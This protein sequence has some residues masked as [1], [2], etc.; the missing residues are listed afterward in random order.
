MGK[1]EKMNCSGPSRF[2]VLFTFLAFVL[3][4]SFMLLFQPL[5]HAV[6]F[7][8]IDDGLYYPRLAQNICNKGVCTYDGITSTNGFH[9]LWL[10]TLLPVYGVFQ[11]P[12]TALKSVYVLI[13]LVQLI[14]FGMF[15][16][17]ARKTRM[18]SSGWIA[19]IFILLLNIRS[20]TIFFSLLESPL[21]LLFYILYIAFC[22]SGGADRFSK[23]FPAFL[24]GILMGLCFL[25]R[26]DSFLLAVAFSVVWVFRKGRSWRSALFS[27]FGCLLLAAPYLA[28]NRIRFGHFETVSAWQKSALHTPVESWNIISSWCLN[29]FVPRVQ[30]VLGL[31]NIPASYLL[32]IML[33]VGLAGLAYAFTG[34]RRQRLVEKFSLFPEYPLFVVLH[35]IFIVMFAPFEAA[36]SAWYWVPEIL[37]AALVAGLCLSDL[38]LFRVPVV[39]AGILL[40]V[41]AQ[42]MLYPKIMERKAMTFAKIEIAEYLREN[43]PEDLRGIMFDSGI[44]SYFSQRDFISLN[45]LIG[46]FEQGQLIQEHRYKELAEKYGVSFLVLD[47][48]I[49]LTQKFSHNVIY[50]TQIKTK[51]ENFQ[52][53]PKSFVAYDVNPVKFEQ[54]WHARYKG[55]R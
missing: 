7:S 1:N 48:P 40:L 53:D 27:A 25:A 26:I 24:S 43:T 49:E 36:A 2:A 5:E 13:F 45:G 42:L 4:I 14:S 6:A 41:I 34:W 44:V 10:L 51:F 38:R 33:L 39:H 12:W 54:I 23:S 15:L 28:W 20:I 46:D 18:G 37:L 8:A 50:E 9:P 47:S 29:Q 16:F 31:E 17:V 22:L 35:V 52:E 55:V 21:V 32:T 11:N 3:C 19:S 30:H